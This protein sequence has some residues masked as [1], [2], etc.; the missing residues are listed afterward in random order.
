MN[1]GIYSNLYYPTRWVPLKRR[2]FG[3]QKCNSVYE[4]H[5]CVASCGIFGSKLEIVLDM[6]GCNMNC[7]YCW[8]W[9]MR[10]S[11]KSVRK[12]PEEVATDILCRIDQVHNDPFILKS[13][14]RVGY[15]RITGNEPTLQWNHLK[16]LIYILDSEEKLYEICDKL[17]IGS[18]TADVIMNS[19]IIIETNGT[20]FGMN[21]IDFDV[22]DRIENLKIDIDI[23]FKGVNYDQFEWLSDMPRE[24]FK[25]QMDGFVK[26]FDYVEDNSLEKIR[27]NPVLGINHAPNYCV[28]KKGK[29][30]I[31]DV[32]IIDKDGNKINFNDSS[33]EFEEK[34]LSRKKL[35]F[36]EAPFREYYGINKDRTRQV[37]AVVYKGKRYLHVLPSEIPDL[38][39]ERR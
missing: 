15:I 30:Y 7:K 35:R 17:K 1:V 36:D 31:M 34:V 4:K 39:T 19:K 11:D 24:Y 33:E 13:K 37:V 18:N 8:G 12:T 27:I 26:L 22:L 21:K 20:L 25:Y 6:K 28:W 38:V 29:K 3:W 14:Y 10:Y 2:G 5:N 32:E 9:K 16:E 23:S